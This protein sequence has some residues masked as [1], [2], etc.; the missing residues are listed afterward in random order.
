MKLSAFLQKR[1]RDTDVLGR[2]G[3]DEFAIYLRNVDELQA[4]T[5]AVQLLK[6]TRRS[7]TVE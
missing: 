7:D 1:L 4:T 5:V 2:L 3:G 6:Q